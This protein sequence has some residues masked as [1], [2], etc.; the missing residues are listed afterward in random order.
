MSTKE[1]LLEDTLSNSRYEIT[2]LEIQVVSL[3]KKLDEL[4]DMNMRLSDR[5]WELQKRVFESMALTGT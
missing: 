1:Q 5:N 2:R 4:S 3:K